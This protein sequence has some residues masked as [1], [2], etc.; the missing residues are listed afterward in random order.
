MAPDSNHVVFCQIKSQ[1]CI[2][3]PVPGRARRCRILKN[4]LIIGWI[5]HLIMFLMVFSTSE[6]NNFIS[7]WELLDGLMDD[8]SF[9]RLWDIFSAIDVVSRPFLSNISEVGSWI[10]I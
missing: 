9:G 6:T 10:D 5:G 1:I 3:L 7:A 2:I 8:E 4:F